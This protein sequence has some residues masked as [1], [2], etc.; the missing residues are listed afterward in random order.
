MDAVTRLEAVA[1]PPRGLPN[2]ATD[3]ITPAPLLHKP[4]GPGYERYL[5]H[6]VRFDAN[7]S[8]K[9]DFILNQA[10]YRAARILVAGDNFGCGSPRAHAVGA[11][12]AP[13][14]RAFLPP[15]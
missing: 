5:F 13:G 1:V 9:P 12:H 4:T 2:V 14:F 6:D 10:P 3:R 8:E 11:L 7:G 15:R